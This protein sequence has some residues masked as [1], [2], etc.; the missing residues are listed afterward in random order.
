MSFLKIPKKLLKSF[1]IFGMAYGVSAIGTGV[2]AQDNVVPD[3]RLAITQNMDFFGGDLQPIFETTFQTCQKICLS[4]T[5]C[6]ALTFNF[7]SNAC[8]PKTEVSEKSPFEGAASAQVYETSPA[9]LQQQAERQR[10]LSFL[11]SW[12]MANAREQGANLARDYITNQWTAEQLVEASRNAR[13]SGNLLNALKFMGAALNLSDSAGGWAEMAQLALEVKPK[14]NSDKR[15]LQQISTSAGINAY[16][17]GLNPAVRVTAL[18]VLARGVEAR[19]NGRQAISVLRL[20]QAIQPRL[21]TED[22]LARVVKLYG[23]R[24]AQHQVDNNAAAPRV[25]V[26]FSENLVKA[27]VDY[28]DFVRLPESGLVVES[29]ATQVCIDGVRHGERYRLTFRA[30]LPAESGEVLAKS[31]DLNVY[32]KDRDPSARFVGR[33]Y[34][35]PKGEAA[36]I[37]IVTVNLSEVDLKIHRVGERNL[38]RA[39]QTRLFGNPLAIWEEKDLTNS[40]GAEVWSGRGIVQR[41]VNQ[42]VTTALPIGDAVKN[43]EPGVYVMRARVPGTDPYDATAAAQ[44]FIVTDLGLSTMKGGDGLHVFV[45]SLNSAAAKVGAAVQLVATNNTVLGEA[46][47]DAQGYAWFA[48]GLIRGKAGSTPA[49]VTV[50][51]GD[52]DFA[53]L[54][55]KDAAFDLSDR[56]VEGR[57]SPPPIDVYLTTDR[58]AYRVGETVYATALARNT[59]A[60]ALVGLPLTAIVTRPDGVEFT[61]ELLDGGKAGGRVFA[62]QLPRSAQRGTWNIRVHSD[63]DASAL[64]AAKFLVED[65]SPERIDFELALQDGP[66][67]VDDVPI[68]T[69]DAKYLYGAPGAGLAVEAETRVTLADG[70]EG[71]RGFKFGREDQFF[72]TRMEFTGGQFETDADG[73][74][75]FGLTMPDVGDVSRPLKMLALVRVREGSG[76]PVERVIEKNLAPAGVLI[77]IKPLFEGVVAEG[78]TAGFEVIAVG[79]DLAQRSL[80][81]VGWTLNRVKT[82]Y[83]WYEN[84]GNWQYEPITTRTRIASG[85]TALDANVTALVEAAVDWGS[86]E[87]K[88]ETLEGEY[89]SASYAF[90]AG[91]FAPA[92]SGN[93][94]D[95]LEVGLNKDSYR[96]GEVAE[97]RLVPRYSGTALITVVSNRLI[98]MKTVEVVEGENLVDLDVTEDWGAGAYV[99]ASVIRPMNVAA[100]HN[101]ARSIGLNWASVDPGMHRLSAEFLTADEVGPRATM[102]AAL[103][104]GGVAEG[105]TAFVTIAAVDVG[106]L[107]LTGFKSP[108]PDDHYFGQRRLGM[109]IRDVYGRLIDGLQ[110]TPG[111]VRS[112]GDGPLSDRTPTPPP[113]DELVAY[114]S[115]PL[116]VDA[117][118][119]VSAE[120]DIPAFNG[121]V[122]LMAVVWSETGVGQAS[123]D[124]LVRDPIVLTASLPRFLAPYDESRI[125]IELAHAKGPSGKVGIEVS[126]SDGLF[127]ETANLPKFVM[128]NE[129]QKITLELPIAAPASGTPEITIALTTPSGDVLRKSLILPIRS[130]DP[131]IAR[132]SR[133]ELSDGDTFTLDNNVFAGFQPGTGHA[134][135]AVGPIARFDAPGLLTALDRYP[136]GCTEQL[137]SRALPLLYFDQVAASLGMADRQNVSERIDQAIAEVLS[138]QSSNGAFGLWRP[139]SGDLWLDAYVSDFLSRARGKGFIVPAQAFRLSMDNLRNRINYAQ[140][141]EKGG[142]AIAY[143]L[144]VLAREGAANIGDLR[145][146][147]DTKA[148]DFA[149]PLALAQLGAALASYGDQ[150]RADAMFRKAGARLDVLNDQP[151][152]QLWRVDYG[153]HLRDTAAVLTLAVEAGSEVLDERALALRITPEATINRGRSTQENMWSLMA[154]NALIEDTPADAFLINGL[155]AGGPVVEVLD[156]QTGAD[157]VVHVL[158]QSG[159]SAS[160]VLTA[161]GVPSEPEPAGGNGYTINRFYFTMDGKQVSPDKVKLNERLVVVLKV[162]PQRYSEA[163]LIVNDPLP[164]GFEIDNPNLL[165]S[166]DVAALDWLLL[167][168]KPQNAEFRSERFVA[169]V[170]WSSDKVF[171]LAYIVRAI[172]PGKFHHPA[173]SVEDMYRPQ[174]RA[175]TAVGVVEVV[176]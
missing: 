124:V 137:T 158:N 116:Q 169:A 14:D 4:D 19:G 165:Q 61:R 130:N 49:M 151:E 152:E 70:L 98:A 48:P 88:L 109:E 167:G 94:P 129:G 100:G 136:H 17:R 155:P 90:Y 148:D 110:G 67:S 28:A 149:T 15:N 173:A 38:I 107:N 133:V 69:V 11:P 23:F 95:T 154:A 32:V 36:A 171:Q 51:D 146:Y 176:R 26:S 123:K 166:G 77:G 9:V 172:S 153:T 139:G 20:S 122:R 105:D 114:F 118:G 12:Y 161:Y 97:L 119:H 57:I 53:F 175:R 27:G 115:G 76:R 92:S 170:D 156:A 45:R 111:Q 66:I 96:I 54:S 60:E 37:P 141:F 18:N 134:T 6:R 43:F 50:R 140:D 99:T 62:V 58:G 120:F 81:R 79:P 74:V 142:E 64:V 138:N 157:R 131:E 16:L 22:A 174:F 3:R 159:K 65:F 145:Y 35:L 86:Y 72:G 78:A 7:K 39:V 1:V 25:C 33:A 89:L 55:L 13:A 44:W 160:T 47:T 85:E 135:L 73:R 5:Q 42:D 10:D 91:W 75:E 82:R 29:D 128:L 168:T 144:M 8:F 68:L 80:A 102:T 103:Q 52:D 147:A 112:G 31:V 56:G 164:A 132:T 150:S 121:T 127:L 59:K 108:D 30:G 41:A 2:F 113:T 163:R 143:A 71:Y 24:V 162:D 21:D 106:V 40:I 34:V 93:T 126:A 117:N 125:L 83:Q 46:V 63:V 84:H 87:I 101:P 104:I